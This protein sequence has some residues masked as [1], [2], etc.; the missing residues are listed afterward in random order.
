MSTYGG[1][2][3]GIVTALKAAGYGTDAKPLPLITAQ[4][5]EVPTMKSIAA[6]EI[7]MS[8]LKDFRITCQKAME[9]AQCI[10]N[11]EDVPINDTESYDNGAFIVPTYLCDI[12]VF[13]IDNMKEVTV[14]SGLFTYEE[15]YG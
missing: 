6:G 14:D 1:M 11:G 2:S 13:D 9:A 8:I 5:A 3:L 12:T 10:I 7:S 4:D 15:I